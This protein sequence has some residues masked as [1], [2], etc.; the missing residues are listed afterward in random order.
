MFA[1]W[2]LPLPL[3]WWRL[4][5]HT[6]PRHL[7]FNGAGTI[8][9]WCLAKKQAYFL[10]V[11]RLLEETQRLREVLKVARKGLERTERCEND[12]AKS[13]VCKVALLQR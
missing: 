6:V 1:A 5:R 12:L 7:P 11:L 13:E 2:P 3:L 4:T 8:H 10:Y 9:S